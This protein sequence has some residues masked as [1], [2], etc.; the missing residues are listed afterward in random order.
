MAALKSR[1]KRPQDPTRSCG[2]IFLRE[3]QCLRMMLDFQ[4]RLI[5]I[6]PELAAAV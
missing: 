3:N 4:P 5:G 1:I 2:L 6:I